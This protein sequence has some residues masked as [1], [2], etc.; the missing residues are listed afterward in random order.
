MAVRDFGQRAD[1]AK[2]QRYAYGIAQEIAKAPK[3]GPYGRA[4]CIRRLE[5]LIREELVK[6]EA[7]I[8]NAD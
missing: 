2:L 8:G 5:S 7:G 6:I 1:D 3:R 4:W